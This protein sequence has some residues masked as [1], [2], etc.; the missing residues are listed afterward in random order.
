MS[1]SGQTQPEHD[2]AERSQVDGTPW[3]ADERG[4]SFISAI[5]DTVGALVVVLDRE[6]RIVQFNQA[7]ERTTGYSFDD[8]AGEN[9]WDLFLIPE[10]VEPVKAVFSQQCLDRVTEADFGSLQDL[11]NLWFSNLIVA[12]L[13]KVDLVDSSASCDDL[14]VAFGEELI[15]WH[16]ERANVRSSDALLKHFVDS[17]FVHVRDVR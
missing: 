1:I 16:L 2:E 10:E 7:C 17:F 14:D 5:L 8:V 6:G 12:L 9:F 15:H 13:V 3:Q 4:R 11:S